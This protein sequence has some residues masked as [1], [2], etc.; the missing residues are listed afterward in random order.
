MGPNYKIAIVNTD[1][2]FPFY[3]YALPFWPYTGQWAKV[4][5]EITLAESGWKINNQR[6]T[7]TKRRPT[8][9]EIEIL[10]KAY[11][12]LAVDAMK[13]KHTYSVKMGYT[14]PTRDWNWLRNW[15]VENVEVELEFSRC[16][17]EETK[18]SGSASYTTGTW[19]LNLV[20]F[21]IKDVNALVHW[22]RTK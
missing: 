6:I 1:H 15:D 20:N 22:W 18:I 13:E 11:P 5:F 14:E 19:G 21:Q 4:K 3:V 8:E 12:E 10:H 16:S 17:C 2:G 9:R 7:V